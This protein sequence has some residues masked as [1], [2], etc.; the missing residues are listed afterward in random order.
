MSQAVEGKVKVVLQGDGGDEMFAGYR[1]YAMLRH[2]Q[3]WNK[4]PHILTPA[5]RKMF[6]RFGKRLAR[7]TDAVGA[8]NA[9]ERM[10]LLM[11]METLNDPP[12]RLLTKDKREQLALNTDPFLSYRNCAQR[13]AEHDPVQ[14]ML[15]TD[16]SLQLPSQFLTKVDRSTMAQSMEVRVPL[17]DEHIGRLAVGMPSK[18]KVQG[19]KNKIALRHS[20]RERLPADIFDGPKTG[21]GVPYGFWLKTSLHEMAKD[22]ILGSDFTQKLGFD[23]DKLES[24]LKQHKA[25][26]GHDGFTLWKIFQLALWHSEYK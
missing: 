15:L 16:I 18:W 7:M 19:A 22:A 23:R 3:I 24:A 5:V 14:Q 4:W 20:M 6:G 2:A 1:R 10:A 8:N 11:T 12:T 9:T 26:Q 13:F 17:L 21:F 25:G